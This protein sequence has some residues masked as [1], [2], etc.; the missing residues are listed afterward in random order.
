MIIRN[1]LIIVSLF[2]FIN[3]LSGQV[4]LSD[5]L[6]IEIKSKNNFTVKSFQDLNIDIDFTTISRKGTYVY[7]DLVSSYRSPF[8]NCYIELYEFDS[9]AQ[10]LK[11]ITREVLGYGHAPYEIKSKEEILLYDL[12]KEF[13]KHGEKRKLTFNLLNF[14]STLNKGEYSMIIYLRNGTAY[15]YDRDGHVVA[16]SIYYLESQVMNFEVLNKVYNP[17]KF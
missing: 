11:N 4:Y 12:K 17:S 10:S 9:V 1:M 14:I 6:K 7:L 2:C 8:G 13:I 16:N 15:G 3:S 5:S